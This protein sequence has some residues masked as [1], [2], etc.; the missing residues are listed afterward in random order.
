MRVLQSEHLMQMSADLDDP[1]VVPDGPVGTRRI[2]YARRG[3]FAGA[4]LRGDLLPGGG[5][6]VLQRSDGIAAL[7]IRF[8]LRTDDGQLLYVTCDGIFD[9]RRRSAS[10][11]GPGA[12]SIR[13]SIT[14]A[15]RSGSRPAQRNIA[16]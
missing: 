12:K 13:P 4:R 1:L 9:S 10:A 2:L 16:G 11:S 3:T 7:D 6:W 14:F 8:V 15:R 5:D